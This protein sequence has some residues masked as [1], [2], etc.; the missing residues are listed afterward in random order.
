RKGILSIIAPITG[1]PAAAAGLKAGDAIL[2]INETIT[3]DLT[4]DEAVRLI[5]GAKGTIVKL[6]ILRE[7]D[8]ETRV[9]E[10]TRDTIRVPVLD[11]EKHEGGVFVVRLHSFTLESP[12]EFRRALEEMARSGSQKLIIDVRNNPGGYLEAAVDIASWFLESGKIV[13]REQRS[14]GS[15]I[16]HRSKGYNAIADIPTVILVNNGSASASEIL[17]GALRDHNKIQ[18]IGTK[19]FGK[20]SVQELIDITENTSLKITIA[21]WLTPLGTSLSD[22]GLDPD[23]M[24]EADKEDQ[25]QLKDMQLERALEIIRAME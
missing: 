13:V 2:Q 6:T 15:E 11:M 18:L 7:G 16:A 3:A 20:G 12:L 25:E 22:N 21:K 24:V 14:D 1:S 19:T 5:R 8:D 17:A 9:A 4:L 10:I 23:V